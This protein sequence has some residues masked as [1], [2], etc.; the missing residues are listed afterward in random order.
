[1][2]HQGFTLIE[3]VVVVALVAI[4]STVLVSL[5]IGHNRI[6]RT[7]TAELDVTGDA[8]QA[9]D[10]IDSYVRQTNRTLSTYST[11][12]ANAQVLI[13]QIQSVNSSSQLI[14]STFDDVVYYLN[15]G[16]LYRQV[17]PNPSSSRTAQ[18]K[19]LAGNVTGLIFTYN[20]PDYAQV[21]EVTTNI[22]VQENAGVQNRA[23][24]TSSKS[25]LRDY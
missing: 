7:Q 12:T 19:K 8:R 3:L 9:L 4:C 15:N 10:D 23:I 17:F 25:K 13:L 21:T 11:Y 24:T 16:N 2:K 14:A 1:M 18:T 22:T 20:N 5:F 6:Y